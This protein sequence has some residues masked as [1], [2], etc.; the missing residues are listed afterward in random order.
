MNSRERVLKA[1]RH[2]E[3]DRVPLDSGG[4]SSTTIAA[5]PYSQLK[6]LL[7]IEEGQ[8]AV[9]DMV[10]QLA[11]VEQWYIDRFEV[12]VVDVTRVFCEDTSDWVDWELPDGTIAKA[13]PWI[14]LEREDGGW[15][16]RAE[17]GTVL[18][19]MPPGG[20]FFDQAYWPMADVGP[21]EYDNPS[22]YMHRT[23]WAS[24]ARPPMQLSRT[25]EFPQLIGSAAKRLHETT[26]YALLFTSGVSLFESA[27]FL[28]GTDNLLADLVTDRQNILRLLD[29]LLEINLANLE[30]QLD[31]FGPYLDVLKINDD[32]G[33]QNGPLISPRLFREV[34]KPRYKVMYDLIKKKNPDMFIFLHSCG[35]IYP[36]LGDL[37]EI[38]LDII[39]PVQTTAKDMEPERLKRE[40]GSDLT[41]WGGGVDTQHVLPF[42]TPEEVALDV[43]EKVRIFA[44]GGG[45]VFNTSH[46]IAPGVPPEN[47][48]SMFEAF[49]RV[50]D[51]PMGR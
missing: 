47:I 9:F 10:Q 34:F 22:K 2:Q 5:L 51:Y 42:G 38:G 28:H 24:M 39:N 26:D 12:D 36:F 37:V 8:V 48:L 33:M 16:H 21:E 25:P 46:N 44:P 20:Y 1:L 23:M 40:F 17:D 45:F 50:R 29:K 27:Q 3:P 14:R 18:G 13:P 30:R 32:L 49:K 11:M 4:C 6:R 41:F 35:S 19:R 31:A 15:V 7:G 43:E